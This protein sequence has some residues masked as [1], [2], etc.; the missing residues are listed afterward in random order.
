MD[1]ITNTIPWTE[2]FLVGAL[3]A[4]LNLNTFLFT[5]GFGIFALYLLPILAGRWSTRTAIVPHRVQRVR[6]LFRIPHSRAECLILH[7]PL[8]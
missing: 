1:N 5:I 6:N 4:Q 8:P 3:A 2:T 7:S